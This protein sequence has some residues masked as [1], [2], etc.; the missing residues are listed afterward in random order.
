MPR[1]TR[2]TAEVKRIIGEVYTR[3]PELRGKP[4]KFYEVVYSQVHKKIDWAEPNWPGL[5]VVKKRLTILREKDRERSPEST[6]LDEPWSLCYLLE[7]P[8]PAEALP[9]VMSMMEKCVNESGGGP[10]Y[11]SWCLSVREA[12]W[13]A[14]LYKVIEF[15]YHKQMAYWADPSNAEL[16]TE[17]RRT[18]HLPKNY[19]EIKFEDIV[20]DWAYAMASEEKYSELADESYEGEEIGTHMIGNIFEYDGERRRDFIDDMAEE[21]GIDDD[22]YRELQSMPIKDVHEFFRQQFSQQLAKRK[23]AQNE[24]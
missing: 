8:I 24:R 9:M 11:E 22:T 5:S 13:V 16:E 1:G 14:R 20:L 7:Y 12:L 4:R 6:E 17:L 2:L 15:Y 18:G 10:H 23:E 3:R 21:Y 19:R